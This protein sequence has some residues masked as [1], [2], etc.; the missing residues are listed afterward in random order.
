MNKAGYTDIATSVGIRTLVKNGMIETTKAMD[1]WNNGQEYIACRLIEKGEGWIL[2]NQ[3]QLQFRL[4][5]N[6]QADAINS[7]PF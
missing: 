7:L 4:T 1:N 6:I 5:K 2:S 3:D